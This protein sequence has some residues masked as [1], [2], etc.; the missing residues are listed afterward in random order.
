MLTKHTLLYTEMITTKSILNNKNNKII[1]NHSN[2][3]P[4]AIQISGYIP[5]ELENVLKSLIKLNK[6]QL[7]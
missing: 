2:Q 6:M 3:H 5:S 4:V 7:V 1:Y